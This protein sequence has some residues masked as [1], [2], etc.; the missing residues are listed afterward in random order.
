MKN[1]IYKWQVGGGLEWR[2]VPEDKYTERQ[3]EHK[4]FIDML[5]AVVQKAQCGWDEVKYKVIEYDD[6]FDSKSY[7]TFMVL[8]ID[9]HEERWIPITGNSMGCNLSV[10]GENLW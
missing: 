1:Y 10:L 5:S 3:K 2:E 8:C 7:S 6:V 4:E 9:G